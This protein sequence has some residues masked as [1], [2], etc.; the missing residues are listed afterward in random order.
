[1]T[2]K[3]TPGPWNINALSRKMTITGNVHQVTDDKRFPTAF[4]PAW[5]APAK[6]E[7]DGT[8]EALANAR[9]IAAAPE[10]LEAAKAALASSSLSESEPGG[11]N[12]LAVEA[13]LRASIAKATGDTQ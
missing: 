1:M 7:I 13:M 10:L 4:V 9:L 8:E 5:D 6:G 12:I 2:D 11:I 3:H